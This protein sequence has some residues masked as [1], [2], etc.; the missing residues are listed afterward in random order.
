M[1]AAID[2]LDLSEQAKIIQEKN[3]YGSHKEHFEKA[4]DLKICGIGY[5]LGKDNFMFVAYSE[6][7]WER[8]VCENLS[9]FVNNKYNEMV[10][11]NFGQEAK[12]VK[13]VV[14]VN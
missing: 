11:Q 12:W 2:N 14:A 1:A 10:S 6:N 4:E 9:M 5:C 3:L 8:S 7:D 13:C